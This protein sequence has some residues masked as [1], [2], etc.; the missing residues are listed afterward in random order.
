[1]KS[2]Q[3]QSAPMTRPWPRRELL[4]AAALTIAVFLAYLPAWNGAFIW[5]DDAHVTKPELRS[6]YGL[7]RIWFDLGAT[8]QYYPLMHSAFWIEH[9]LWGDSPLGY[10]LVNIF[11]HVLV[12]LMVVV[13]LSKLKIPGAYLAGAIFALHPVQVESVAWITELKNTLSAVLYLAAAWLYLCFDENRKKRFYMGALVVFV[14]CLLS[15]TVTATLP[16]ALLVVFWWKRGRLSWRR[17]VLPLVPFFVL[18]AAAG[19]FTA[20]VERKLIGAEGAEFDL[21]FIDRFLIAGRVIWFYLGKLFW[22]VDLMFIYPRWNV[23]QAVWWQYLF[24]ITALLSAFAL[25]GLQRR[26]RGPLAGM[27]FFVGTLFPVLGFF[28]VFPFLYSFVADHFQYLASL[29][30][31]ALVSA[32]IALLLERCPLWPRIGGYVLCVSVLAVLAGLTWR[33]CLMYA[34]LETLYCTTLEKNP[35]CWMAH[36][37]LGLIFYQNGKIDEGIEHYKQ[38]IKI[39]PNNPEAYNDMGVGLFKK[40]QV[41]EAIEHYEQALRL[42]PNYLEAHNNLGLVM[43]KTGKMQEAIEKFQYTLKIYPYYI[44]SLNNLGSALTQTGRPKEAIEL[45]RRALALRPDFVEVHINLSDALIQT[46]QFQE[47][48]EHCQQALRLKPNSVEA[49]N[50]LGNAF[51]ATG[52]HQKAIDCFEKALK[53]DPDYIQTYINLGKTLAGMGK[54]PEAVNRYEQALRLKPESVEAHF[55]LGNAFKMGGQY[56]QAI[57]HYEKALQNNADFHQARVNLAGVLVQAGRPQEAIEHC[58]Q[59]LRQ[60][61]DYPEAHYFLGSAM[62]RMNKPQE[63]IE[64]FQE[65]LRLKPDYPEVC[66]NLGVTLLQMGKPEQA[67][68]QFKEALRLKPDYIGAYFNLALAYADA[69]QSTEAEAAAQKGLELARSTGQVNLA[70]QIENWLNAYHLKLSDSPNISPDSPDKL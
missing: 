16:A 2:G 54:L 6:W 31:I 8:Q 41:Q 17:D 59:A 37:N 33:Q 61:P 12:A 40:G 46:G 42:R 53:L 29:G 58:R 3:N 11:L 9:K 7:Y 43:L 26:W 68:A 57:E 32:G 50:T 49:Q 69:G 60:K 35:D 15:K 4:F 67:V 63:A 14:L 1:M 45:Y 22:P 23:A 65:V 19:L 52:Q 20:W 44:E 55:N 70:K 28:N 51:D 34:D 13:L 5:D 47:A 48:I 38:S 25:W 66:N 27:L 18:G 62:L 30:V 21:T 36:N 24:P 64:H 39:Y 56:E 10:H